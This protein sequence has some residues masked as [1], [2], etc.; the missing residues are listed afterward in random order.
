MALSPCFRK[1]SAMTEFIFQEM[2][3][4]GSSSFVMV[5]HGSSSST[6]PVSK[7]PLA[8]LVSQH[9]LMLYKAAHVTLFSS[10]WHCSHA[11][12]LTSSFLQFTVYLNLYFFLSFLY[13]LFPGC[14]KQLTW[15]QRN[16][17]GCYKSSTM[18]FLSVAAPRPF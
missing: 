3:R 4:H 14:L 5:L 16:I 9:V 6:F 10:Y 7:N 13:L 2:G 17:A 15:A 12:K 11:C 8:I 18:S 1:V